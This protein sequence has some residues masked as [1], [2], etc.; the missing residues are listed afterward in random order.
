MP[1][2]TISHI[3]ALLNSLSMST[4]QS[5]KEFLDSPLSVNQTL[6]S[7]QMMKHLTTAPQQQDCIL[8]ST[9]LQNVMVLFPHTD[10]VIISQWLQAGMLLLLL[11]I[12]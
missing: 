4:P 11:F 2:T 9:A 6:T 7:G 3:N 5:F 12:D 1:C 8:T 10:I